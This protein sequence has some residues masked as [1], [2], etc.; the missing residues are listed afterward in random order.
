MTPNVGLEFR[1][2]N[3]CIPTI[4]ASPKQFTVSLLKIQPIENKQLILMS[5]ACS[6]AAGFALMIEE[7]DI[8]CKKRNEIDKKI[9]WEVKNRICHQAQAQANNEHEN[10]VTES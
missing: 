5:D 10:E 2:S 4:S 3:F 6:S 8:A 7:K 1:K 9:H